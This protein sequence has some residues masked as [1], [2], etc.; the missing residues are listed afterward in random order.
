M[1]KILLEVV[2]VS[3][4]DLDAPLPGTERPG[5]PDPQRVVHGVGQN[6]AAV[7]ILNFKV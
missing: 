6:V 2:I 7:L 1:E 3:S 4:E 5:V